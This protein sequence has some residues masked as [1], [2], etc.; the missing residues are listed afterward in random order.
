MEVE[1]NIKRKYLAFLSMLVGVIAVIGFAIAQ[2]PAQYH[3]P[4]EIYPQGEGSGLDADLLDGHNSSYYLFDDRPLADKYPAIIY[5]TVNYYNGNLGGYAGFDEKCRTDPGRPPGYTIYRRSTYRSGYQYAKQ[6]DTSWS[7]SPP[8]SV[9]EM[10]SELL[11]YGSGGEGAIGMWG[12]GVF[13]GQ[14]CNGWT[15]S[16]NSYRMPV[17]HSHWIRRYY[18]DNTEFVQLNA[19][20][21]SMPLWYCSDE[22]HLLCEAF[23]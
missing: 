7:S 12:G 22:T 4:S 19:G 10:K 23:K 3:P 18:G 14:D 13:S 16:S 21:Y 9:S 20:M 11:G 1:I 8:V 5:R 2:A 6:G 17:G 15:S